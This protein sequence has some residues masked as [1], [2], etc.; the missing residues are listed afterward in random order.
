[1]KRDGATDSRWSGFWAQLRRDYA[2]LW[3]EMHDSW[4]Q[5]REQW[6]E[7]IAEIRQARQL[8]RGAKQRITG[9]HNPTRRQVRRALRGHRQDDH[10]LV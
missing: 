6:W 3:P 1:M 5:Q 2:R 8:D 4:R 7:T 9:L 10:G